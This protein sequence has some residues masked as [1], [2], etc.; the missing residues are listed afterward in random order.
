LA[1]RRTARAVRPVRFNGLT[2]PRQAAQTGN[3]GAAMAHTRYATDRGLIARMGVTMFLIGLVFVAFIAAL[4]YLL[5]A[6]SNISTG[7]VVFLAVAAALAGR[8]GS[9]FW[10]GKIALSTS[11]A[12]LVTPPDGPPAAEPPRGLHPAW[13]AA[14]QPHP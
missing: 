9:Y 4:V 5:G 1:C 3:G 2:G 7:G 11:R 10:S 8:L 13:A 6:F 14:P 12:P